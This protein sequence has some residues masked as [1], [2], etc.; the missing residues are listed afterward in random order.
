MTREDAIKLRKAIVSGNQ[1]IPD[2]I[3]IDTYD[4]FPNWAPGMSVQIGERYKYNGTLY[5]VIQ[6]HTTQSDWTPDIVP[7]LFTVV[8]TET[9]P[10]WQQPTGGHDA[11][12]LGDRVTHNGNTWESTVNANVWAPGVFGWI[13]I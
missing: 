4:L 11:Y 3:A 2:D 1:C 12:N 8:S 10:P 7:A 9:T 6:A 5:K 13:I